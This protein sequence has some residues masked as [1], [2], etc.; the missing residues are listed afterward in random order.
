MGTVAAPGTGAD[1]AERDDVDVLEY[2]A[3]SQHPAGGRRVGVVLDAS[4]ADAVPMQAV[5]ADVDLDET[6]FLFPVGDDE[7]VAR[8]F[9]RA[10]ELTSA[11]HATIAAAVAHAQRRGPGSVRLYTHAGRV[12]VATSVAGGHGLTALLTGPSTRLATLADDDL[13]VLLDALGLQVD[14]LDAAL[15]P[16]V[17][18]AGTWHPVLAVHDRSLLDRPVR[19]VVALRHLLTARGWTTV[20]LVWRGARTAYHCRNPL[21]T[22]GIVDDRASSGAAAALVGYL[23]ALSLVR[24]PAS[25]SV[26][27]TDERGRTSQL[28]LHVPARSGRGIAIV[29]HA[30][31]RPAS[32][33][34]RLDDGE[35]LVLAGR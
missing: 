8:F 18:F 16:W 21:L 35:V 25:V 23:R 27:Q 22:S 26:L 14:D 5:A 3:C 31:E 24:P 11:A 10:T 32:A 33:L 9:S 7:F 6:V 13:A 15:P 4:G 34:R 12:D 28:A 30:S 29:G 2:T 19:D 20:D 1:G 17:S